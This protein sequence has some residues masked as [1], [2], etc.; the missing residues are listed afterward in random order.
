MRA[1]RDDERTATRSGKRD[2]RLVF[3]EQNPARELFDRCPSGGGGPSAEGLQRPAC[4]RLSCRA[5]EEL[6]ARLTQS[7]PAK[8]VPDRVHAAVELL[9]STGKDEYRAIPHRERIADPGA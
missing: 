8:A 5:A 3:T 2:D 6:V 1:W 9:L 7:P 4:S